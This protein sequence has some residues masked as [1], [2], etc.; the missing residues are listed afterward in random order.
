MATHVE[1]NT[2]PKEPVKI[3]PLKAS[4]RSVK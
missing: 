2:A 4:K 1:R 3:N